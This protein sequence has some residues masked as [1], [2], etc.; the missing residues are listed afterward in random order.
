MKRLKRWFNF[1]Y[2]R[3][4]FCY[5]F[6]VQYSILSRSFF[7]YLFSFNVCKRMASSP[8]I[9]GWRRICHTTIEILCEWLCARCLCVCVR[10]YVHA[11]GVH[12]RKIVCHFRCL[13]YGTEMVNFSKT[14][15]RNEKV[16]HFPFSTLHIQATKIHWFIFT[17]WESVKTD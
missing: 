8:Q 3:C 1:S 2:F 9:C 13:R 10:M 16:F 7:L 15:F 4:I 14:H 6:F 5:Y 11:C 17:V 12:D